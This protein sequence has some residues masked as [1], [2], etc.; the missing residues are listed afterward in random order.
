M[1]TRFNHPMQ[2]HVSWCAKR[3]DGAPGP[4]ETSFSEASAREYAAYIVDEYDEPAVITYFECCKRCSGSGM[5]RKA[6]S[7]V[8]YAMTTCKACRGSGAEYET[9]IETIDRTR[10]PR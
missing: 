9:H 5:V 7:R 3:A 6:R 2:K 10:A 1:S 4:N 8:L